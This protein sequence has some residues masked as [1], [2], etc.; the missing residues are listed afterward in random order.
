MIYWWAHELCRKIKTVQAKLSSDASPKEVAYNLVDR[1]GLPT[2][3]WVGNLLKASLCKGPDHGI[4]MLFGITCSEEQEFDPV[5]HFDFTKCTVTVDAQC[6]NMGMKNYPV[7]SWEGIRE[8]LEVVPL[9][10][11]FWRV[12]H[13]L[14]LWPWVGQLDRERQTVPRPPTIDELPLVPIEHWIDGDTYIQNFNCGHC[15]GVQ[16]PTAGLLLRHYQAHHDH[17]G[18]PYPQLDMDAWK[19]QFKVFNETFR[20]GKAPTLRTWRKLECRESGCPETFALYEARRNHERKAHP[21]T[22]QGLKCR[23]PGCDETFVTVHLR[24]IHERDEHPDLP[25]T[26]ECRKSGCGETFKATWQRANHERRE[27]PEIALPVKCRKPGCDKTFMAAYSRD[28]H[29]RDEHPDIAQSIKCR[30]P[31]CGE[32]FNST[33]GRGNHERRE[34]PDIAPGLKCRKPG[35]DETFTNNG[36]RIL[37]EKK[38]HKE[39]EGDQEEHEEGGKGDM[40]GEGKRKRK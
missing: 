34:H 2:M 4:A 3:P 36:S 23:K 20:S 9:S 40:G 17:G 19:E 15:E 32:T 27:H 14:G 39:E 18:S 38:K 37:Y 29:E 28:K 12:D 25:P 6:T 1:W 33:I 21:E 8:A 24:E 16:F 11:P 5:E 7:E 22:F 30:K 31:D 35:C 13:D 26:H 10:H